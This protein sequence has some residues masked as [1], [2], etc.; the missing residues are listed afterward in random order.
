M[1]QTT[2]NNIVAGLKS[3]GATPEII[4]YV[5]A[6]QYTG[7]IP[8][9]S[10][11]VDQIMVPGISG[12]NRKRGPRSA[13]PSKAM[14][15]PTETNRRRGRPPIG[16]GTQDLISYISANPGVTQA[17]LRNVFP[18]VAPKVLGRRLGAA[19]K[20]TK[21]RPAPLI[22]MSGDGYWPASRQRQAA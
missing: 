9:T 14:Q 7:A 22:A 16:V 11:T 5:T 6:L 19:C 2:Q 4:G 20:P 18:T 21:A 15:Q 12:P 10:S 3:L 1:S 17:T 8:T 13:K